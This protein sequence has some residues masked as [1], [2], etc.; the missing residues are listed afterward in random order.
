[1]IICVKSAIRYQYVML[2]G[3]SDFHE[4]ARGKL[5]LTKI[6]LNGRMYRKR[7]SAINEP[8]GTVCILRHALLV[9]QIT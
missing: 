2:V 6:Q 5:F 4:I 8:L 9:L 3:I 1:M 7:K